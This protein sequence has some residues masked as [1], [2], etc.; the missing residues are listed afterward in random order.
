MKK[1]KFALP[2]L[3]V[4]LASIFSC[5]SDDNGLIVVPPKDRGE[6]ALVAQTE[7]EDYLETHYYNYE[8]FQ[9]PPAEFDFKIVFGSL[10]DNPDK[11]PLSEQV[12]SKTV[13][14][15][16]DSEVSYTLYYLNA[17]QGEG[18]NI[19][20]PD[21][22]TVSYEG[23]FVSSGIA[24]DGSVSPVRFDL[25]Q[26]LD[27]LQDGM[28]EFNAS[29]AGPID[30]PDGTV[31]Y[32]EFGVGAV[33][34]PSG[35]GYFVNPPPTSGIPAYAQLIFTFQLF[36]AE[37]GDQDGDGVVSVLEDVNQNGIEED[38]DT[39]GDFIPNYADIDDDGDG[40]LTADEIVIDDDGN[41][42]FPDT[43]GDGIPD[44][45]DADNS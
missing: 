28:V 14:D 33:F 35:L 19:N 40:T 2:I 30:N 29:S 38:D 45:L 44:Y 11:T 23:S 1:V 36:Q 15:R 20:F 7:I 26:V 27:G 31:S 43:D 17:V 25:T 21:I 4:V 5:K 18:S 3:V 6:E 12:S 39:D 34:I 32:E 13:Q 42:S 10:E 37:V 8:E 16:V 9:N 22:S 41:V 24:F